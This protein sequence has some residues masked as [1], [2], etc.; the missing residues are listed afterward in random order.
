VQHKIL[1]KALKKSWKIHSPATA[2]H[3][4]GHDPSV[5]AIISSLGV[6]NDVSGHLSVS[7]D[8]EFREDPESYKVDDKLPAALAHIPSKLSDTSSDNSETFLYGRKRSAGS[9]LDDHQ[10]PTESVASSASSLAASASLDTP[11]DKFGEL[12]HDS[13]QFGQ[14]KKSKTRQRPTFCP[15]PPQA[16]VTSPVQPTRMVWP[17]FTLTSLTPRIDDKTW[18]G[19][20]SSWENDVLADNIPF[21]AGLTGLP[22]ADSP[23]NTWVEDYP[24]YTFPTV[25][26]P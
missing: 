14:V 3:K 7:P 4:L 15:L 8:F 5:H 19:V 1:I 12:T 13:T 23:W 25:Q 26:A 10:S 21:D 24:E 6:L 9:T 17:D 22:V 16:F 11:L 2:Q 18:Q 20:D